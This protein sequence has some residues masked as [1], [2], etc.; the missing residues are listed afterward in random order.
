M[1]TSSQKPGRDNMLG[2]PNLKYFDT[3]SKQ[4]VVIQEG[5]YGLKFIQSCF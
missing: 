5:S 4:E 1:K 3:R 2:T